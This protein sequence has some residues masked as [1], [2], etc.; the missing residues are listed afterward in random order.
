MEPTKL[1]QTLALWAD[2]LRDVTAM[3]SRFAPTIYDR[4]NY[5]R[6]RQVAMEMLALATEQPLEALVPLRSFFAR[7]TPLA[8]GDGAVFNERGEILLIRRADTGKWAM[9]G[10]A[11]MVGESA[12]EGTVREVLEETGIPCEAVALAAVHDSRL[13][14]SADGVHLYHFLFVCRPLGEAGPASHGHEVLE[15][16]W[17]R[18]EEL[19]AEWHPGHA[20]RVPV[21]FRVWRGEARAYF[22]GAPS[23]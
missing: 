18:E 5:E 16:R 20:P 8:G 6:V 15:T 7:P 10:G 11:L 14:G 17:F 22:D 13:C 4:E 2:T 3:G 9:P 1:A 12:A 19:P 23:G 21:A